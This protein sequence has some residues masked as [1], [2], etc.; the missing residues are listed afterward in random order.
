MEIR[1]LRPKDLP[2]VSKLAGELVRLHSRTDSARFMR[3]PHVEDGYA[4]WFGKQLKNRKAVLLVAEEKG[5]IRGYAYGSM[6]P[7]DWNMLLDAH[8]AIHDVCVAR[9][10]RRR[11]VG[12][13]LTE[14][15][16]EAL[17][18]KGAQRI[19]LSTMVQNEP[20]QR[21]FGSLGF[22]STMLEMTLNPRR[23]RNGGS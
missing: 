18:V 6:E 12:R 7:R 14:A 16:V 1:P 23:G 20:A 19:L 17:T 5:R 10:G 2:M 15:M 22:R 11:G 13:A 21:L 4:W 8:G 3:I 9:T